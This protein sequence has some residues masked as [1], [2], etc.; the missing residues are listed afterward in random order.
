MPMKYDE[1]TGIPYFVPDTAIELDEGKTPK[2]DVI[3]S[4][5][6]QFAGDKAPALK[7]RLADE[8][9]KFAEG[10]A[11]QIPIEPGAP[12]VTTGMFTSG[13]LPGL[14]PAISPDP[15]PRLFDPDEIARKATPA[16]LSAKVA[17]DAE[18]TELERLANEH[19]VMHWPTLLRLIN[20]L[21]MTE[22]LLKVERRN[23]D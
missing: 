6:A 10:V 1:N 20:R 9:I 8:A 2:P 17:T 15:D 16:A 5:T 23:R 11:N 12:S 7:R 22:E 21:R 13:P 3:T 19:S 18:I 4:K 14:D